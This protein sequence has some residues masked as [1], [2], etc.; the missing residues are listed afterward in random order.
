MFSNI[1]P[2]IA[3]KYAE[4]L[5]ADAPVSLMI[6]DVNINEWFRIS[7]RKAILNYICSK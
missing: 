7:G 6:T 2:L 3:F 1:E 4:T 5:Q